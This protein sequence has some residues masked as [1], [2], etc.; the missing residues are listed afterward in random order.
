VLISHQVLKYLYKYQNPWRI[1]ITFTQARCMCFCNQES[2]DYYSIQTSNDISIIDIIL[3]LIVLFDSLWVICTPDKWQQRMPQDHTV[4]ACIHYATKQPECNQYHFSLRF[5]RRT[6]NWNLWRSKFVSDNLELIN[7][8]H[9][10]LAY[11]YPYPNT[12]LK[13]EFDLTKQ[14]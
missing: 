11:D 14:I 6:L 3:W 1:C 8:G 4:E 7:R 13:S 9:A 5:W 10:H 2:S 12:T